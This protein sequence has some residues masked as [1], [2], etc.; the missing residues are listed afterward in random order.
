M[1]VIVKG[2]DGAIVHSWSGASLMP[3]ALT[4]DEF[5]RMR[6]VEDDGMFKVVR[7]PSGGGQLQT[8]GYVPSIGFLI[9]MEDD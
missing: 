5:G 6:R 9:I 3:P 7:M 8:L 2:K 1:K 4:L